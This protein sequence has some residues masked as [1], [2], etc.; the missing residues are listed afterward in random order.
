MTKKDILPLLKESASQW[1]D[2]HCTRLAAALAYYTMLSIAPLLVIFVKIVGVWYSNSQEAQTNVTNYLQ[3]FVGSQSAQAL[4]TMTAKA[5][6]PGSGTMATVISF[7]I[8]LFS[9]GGVFGELQ[10]SMNVVFNVTPKPNQGWMAIVKQRFFSLTL[11]LGTGFLLLVSLIVSTVLSGIVHSIGVSWF[12][13]I[14]NFI[15]SF[16]VITCLFAL[17]FKYLPDVKLPWR[18]VWYGAGLTAILFTIGKFGL[19]IYLSHGSTISVFGAAG[20][21]AALLI[22]TYYSGLILFFG[23]EFTQA[24]AKKLGA[25]Q[26][27]AHAVK[28]TEEDR[29][30]RGAPRKETIEH[31]TAEFRPMPSDYALARPRPVVQRNPVG[32]TVAGLA[33]GAVLGGVGYWLSERKIAGV[34]RD[35]LTED[36]ERRIREVEHKIN[37]RIR[38]NRLFRARAVDDYVSHYK[39]ANRWHVPEPV[40]EFAHKVLHAVKQRVV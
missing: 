2:D 30:H 28:M 9:A 1:S 35:H 34:S 4:Q 3:N 18:A 39:A 33:A 37:E 7:A 19:G 22:W 5:S 13:N 26:P 11:V 29:I 14:V 38:Q 25:I 20:S 24:I 12:W 16:A 8:L 40:K 6:Q 36:V 31:A 27:E 21:L 23:A 10:D 17:I 32:Y 15:V